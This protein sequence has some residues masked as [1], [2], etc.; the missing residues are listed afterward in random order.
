MCDGQ[1]CYADVMGLVAIEVLSVED[2]K[3]VMASNIDGTFYCSSAVLPSMRTSGGGLIIN[4][5]SVP[6]FVFFSSTCS[7]LFVI[8]LMRVGC[9]PS[10]SSSRWRR[11]LRFKGRCQCPRYISLHVSSM[12]DPFLSS[13]RLDDRCG[14]LLAQHPRD[15]HLS[16]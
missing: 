8:V 12:A 13:C 14:V 2:F 16:R 9:C 3:G 10:W 4:I 11:L 1:R 15:Q 5:S 6:L 7:L